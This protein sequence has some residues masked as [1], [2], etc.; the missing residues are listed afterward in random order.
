MKRQPNL[1]RLRLANGYECVGLFLLQEHVPV[2]GDS[3]RLVATGASRRAALWLRGQG[4]LMLQTWDGDRVAG[5]SQFLHLDPLTSREAARAGGLSPDTISS[6]PPSA[7][8]PPGSDVGSNGGPGFA[9]SESREWVD[10]AGESRGA[11]FD[12]AADPGLQAFSEGGA[13]GCTP[14]RVE[15]E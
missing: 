10:A 6:A 14:R 11:P 2:E 7:S 4:E 1:R 13:E 3:S 8:L 5:A 9:A 15:V 12:A